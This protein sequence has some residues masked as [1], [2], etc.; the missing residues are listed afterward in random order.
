VRV[1]AY[2]LPVAFAF[3]FA[4]AFVGCDDSIDPPVS[5]PVLTVGRVGDVSGLD[6]SRVDD[7]LSL[8]VT[9][10]VFTN[11][12]RFRPGTSEI[13]PGIA[14]AW[15]A[16]NGGKTWTFSLA[17]GQ[18]FSDGT[19]LDAAAVKFNFERWRAARD[20]A[21]LGTLGAIA[22]VAAPDSR[23]L[24]IELDVPNPG[25][26]VDLALPQFGIGSPSAIAKSPSDFDAKPV[27]AGPY[28][29]LAWVR[30]EY[31]LLG[32]NPL[33]NGPKPAYADIYIRDIPDPPTTVLAMKKFDIDVL[34]EPRPEDVDALA[35]APGV[36]LY[37]VPGNGAVAFAA[38]DSIDGIVASPDG[39]F[40]FSAMKP[41]AGS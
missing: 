10:E 26:A 23:T 41:R 8:S 36:R 2:A 22:S 34:V 30:G 33:W 31:V 37:R 29:V 28:E 18:R 7:D 4:F 3:A 35:Q 13:E 19:A 5:G 16:S 12:V 15:R 14:R 25:F 9:R 38:K 27:A 6:P 40:N 24:V 39:S 21:Y 1:A 11:L 17:P 32:A 20:P